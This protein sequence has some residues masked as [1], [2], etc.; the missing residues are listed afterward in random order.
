MK[1]EH[2]GYTLIEILIVI[3][4]MAL[5]GA[6]LL[7]AVRGVVEYS[8]VSATKA[9]I[10]KISRALEDKTDAFNRH[11]ARLNRQAGPNRHPKYVNTWHQRLSS[12]RKGLA[13]ILAKKDEYRRNFIQTF[14]EDDQVVDVDPDPN[15]TVW[16]V[17][18]NWPYNDP[19]VPVPED[20]NNNGILDPGEDINGNGRLD[21]TDD[22][23]F[24]GIPNTDFNGNLIEDVNGDGR[25]GFH[26]LESENA[27]CLYYIV[28]QGEMFGASPIPED[29]FSSSEVQDTDGDGLMEFVDAWGNPLRFYRWP[30][31]MI[32]PNDGSFPLG[33]RQAIRDPNLPEPQRQYRFFIREEWASVVFGPLSLKPR[34]TQG[35]NPPFN[36]RIY[37]GMPSSDPLPTLQGEFLDS[38]ARDSDDLLGLTHRSANNSSVGSPPLY[39]YDLPLSPPNF[40]SRFHTPDTYIRPLVMSAGPDEELGIYEPDEGSLIVSPPQPGIAFGDKVYADTNFGRLAQPVLGQMAEDARQDN[41]S[42]AFLRPSK[43]Q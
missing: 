34:E 27:E 3:G 21:I 16:R 12:D 30:T 31:R 18:L 7:G 10:N 23:N 39:N 35:N 38:L 43:A 36:S 24:D 19:N 15:S 2:K 20:V 29:A 11:I 22:A 6:M 8:Q 4:L 13:R 37:V 5:L 32:R 25:W 40:E 41:I 1:E 9:T 14:A 17:Q 28:T 33:F 26:T 42:S